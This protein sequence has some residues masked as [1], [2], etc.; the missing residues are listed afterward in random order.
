MDNQCKNIQNQM[1]DYIL[2][3]L[4]KEQIDFFEQHINECEQCRKILQLLENE[5]R[6]L[7]QFGND[8]DAGMLERKVRAI[9]NLNNSKQDKHSEANSIWRKIMNSRITQLSTAAILIFGTLFAVSIID[10]TASSAYAFSQTVKA[11]KKV[12]TVYMEGE[13]Y[14]Q[15]N[16]ECWM[17]YDGNPDKPTHVWLGRTGH[18]LCKICSPVGVF[19]LNMRTNRVYFAMRDERNKDWILKF[20]SF[21]EDAVN[22]ADKEDSINVYNETDPDTGVEIIVVSIKTSNREQE[23][24]VDPETKLPVS[25]TT[26][27][28]DA[29]MEMM[30]KT[31]AV[32]NI[33]E[34]HYNEEPP[35][36]IF[37]MPP[38][39]V[40]VEEEVDCMV[41][42]D[43]GLIADNMSKEEAC[44]EIVEQTGQALIDLDIDTLCKLDLFF[45]L[46]PPDIWEQIRKMK[47]NGQWVSEFNI[48]GEPYQEGEL[49]YV[50][51]EI[52]TADGQGEIQNPMLKF[53]EMEGSIYCFI[54]GSKEK[55]VVD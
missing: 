13:F 34:I 7:V 52:K 11:I 36:G 8:L 30:G 33:T 20:A 2:E 23:F 32:K 27:K 17:K 22:K 24:L 51:C 46:Y 12:E 19:G 10:K 14:R 9:E 54:I 39:A 21:F 37:E 43:S 35:E 42:P 38:D 18:N 31:L 5:N 41:D 55:G 16:F 49:W 25:F 28:D 50:P 29:P 53:Y 48:T 6:L 15:G 4:K 47:E 40:V 1:A 45:R 44:L 26:V 3:T